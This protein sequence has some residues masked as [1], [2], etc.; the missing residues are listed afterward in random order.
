MVALN[1]ITTACSHCTSET[2]FEHI[3]G[4]PCFEV[5]RDHVRAIHG[6]L[7]SF[8]FRS[9]SCLLNLVSKLFINCCFGKKISVSLSHFDTICDKYRFTHRKP[10]FFKRKP[11]KLQ[12]PHLRYLPDGS[13]YH[14]SFSVLVVSLFSFGRWNVRDLLLCQE[15]GL[16]YYIITPQ[17]FSFHSLS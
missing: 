13:L 16:D 8:G 10:N 14:D 1:C 12:W 4:T 15:T 11:L 2:H 6:K 17:I 7:S 3:S 9:I 5:H